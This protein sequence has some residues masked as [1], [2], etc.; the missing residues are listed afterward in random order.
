[1]GTGTH[2]GINT[3]APT[4]VWIQ[5]SVGHFEIHPDEAHGPVLLYTGKLCAYRRTLCGFI[6]VYNLIVDTDDYSNVCVCNFTKINGW[7]FNYSA[8]VTLYQLWQYNYM[9]IQDLL[10]TPCWNE[11]HFSKKIIIA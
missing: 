9:L 4:F 6:F 1:M 7:D 5:N 3:K 2:L 11:S 10:P 8:P